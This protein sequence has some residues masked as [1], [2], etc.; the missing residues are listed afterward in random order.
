[1][2]NPKEL[3]IKINKRGA[4]SQKIKTM[5]NSVFTIAIKGYLPDT[6]VFNKSRETIMKLHYKKRK[7][8]W[9]KY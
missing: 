8:K 2:F 6:V 7:R 9:G 4:L 3:L 5:K 1:M